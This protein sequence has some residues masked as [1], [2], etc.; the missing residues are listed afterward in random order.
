METEES[1]ENLLKRGRRLTDEARTA[2]EDSEL[3]ASYEK[4]DRSREAYQ[5]ALVRARSEDR[6]RVPSL[7]DE[8][9]STMLKKLE[10]SRKAA[11]RACDAT[12]GRQ[13][14]RQLSTAL[15]RLDET[16][17]ELEH[18][19]MQ[20]YSLG[21]VGAIREKSDDIRE[22]RETQLDLQTERARNLALLA[23]KRREEG[24]YFLAAETYYEAIEVYNSALQNAEELPDVTVEEQIREG[25]R[26][27]K[28]SL[29]ELQEAEKL[30]GDACPNCNGTLPE[31]SRFCPHCG[32]DPSDVDVTEIFRDG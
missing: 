17:D 29:A 32:I 28:D 10:T 8:I 19:L 1:L 14:E 2:L 27:A 18:S 21:N 6:E 3:D 4:W 5:K 13:K 12:D 22:A 20:E 24:E 9:H 11:S 7:K 15:G 31:N 23:S 30:F 26:E 16:I 25:V